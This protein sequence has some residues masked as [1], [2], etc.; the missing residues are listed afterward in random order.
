MNDALIKIHSVFVGQPQ[1]LR[2][3]R[4]TWRSSIFRS[5]VNGPV[6]LEVRGLA[7][8]QATQPFHGSPD[9]AVCC[10]PLDHY[11]FWKERLGMDLRPGNVGENWVLEGADEDAICIGDI[12]R[13]GTA[14]VQV[15]GP[16]IPCATQARRVGRGDWVKLTLQELR[17]GFF[18]RVLAP[19]AVQAGDEWELSERVDAEATLRSVNRC[20]YHQFAASL[21]R[22]F[23]ELEGL[24]EY[25]RKM[26]L[27]KLE[28]PQQT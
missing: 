22:R 13:V 21:A 1:T 24:A 11:R 5:E 19:G 7:G 27:E 10:H 9:C 18:L 2:D 4:G 20:Y 15:S 23:A 26:F 12:Y 25:W 6:E 16:R 14:Q 8:D 3:E 17:T 28:L